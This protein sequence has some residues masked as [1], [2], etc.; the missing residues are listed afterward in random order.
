MA[1]IIEL[2]DSLLPQDKIN[3]FYLELPEG[4]AGMLIEE[5]GVN[6][7]ITSFKGYD[8]V[9]SSTIQFYIRVDKKSGNYGNYDALIKDFYKLVQSK[10]GCEKD[11]IKLLYVGEFTYTPNLRDEKGNYIFSLLFPV[12][13]KEN[14]E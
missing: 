9:I 1:N 3:I 4:K 14:K 13:Y 6:G 10:V 5:T 12:I 8:G 11:N 7:S 2:V